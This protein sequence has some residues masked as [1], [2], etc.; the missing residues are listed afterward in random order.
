LPRPHS[1][2]V[3]SGVDFA[4]IYRAIQQYLSDGC[5]VVYSAESAS[6]AHI[7]KRMMQSGF[8]PDAEDFI[9][10]GTLTIVDEKIVSQQKT[11]LNAT[12]L[13]D[14]LFFTALEARRKSGAKRVVVICNSNLLLDKQQFAKQVEFEQAINQKF[15]D[16]KNKE[17]VEVICCYGPANI[18]NLS[19]EHLVSILNSHSG[20]IV[21]KD[22]RYAAWHP[23]V[24]LEIIFRG[25]E[26]SLDPQTANLI[27][28]TLKLVYK[29][30]EDAIISN[31]ALFEQTLRKII[32]NNAA[33]SV[34][35]SIQEQ[36]KL[37]MLE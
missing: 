16:G 25:I 14:M 6:F 35:A 1:M 11:H 29:I 8:I 21:D 18:Q 5:A 3:K 12:Q 33:D 20:M 9:Q 26:K 4:H 17:Q 28:K 27:F 19:L 30:D 22:W 13:A 7:L 10:N 34:L 23:A 32:G 36:A 37:Q 24:V 15:K 31:P 2:V